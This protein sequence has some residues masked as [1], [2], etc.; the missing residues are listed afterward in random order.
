MF[1]NSFFAV[2]ITNCSKVTRLS[3][4]CPLVTADD[5]LLTADDEELTAIY[6]L[7]AGNS[8]SGDSLIAGN[9]GF[10]ALEYG[11]LRLLEYKN[12][13]LKYDILLYY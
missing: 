3:A 6:D 2:S 7:T 5:D 13:L 1:T 8:A 4:G 10:S 11:N 9:Y 12:L